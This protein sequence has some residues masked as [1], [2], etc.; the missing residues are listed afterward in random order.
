MKKESFSEHAQKALPLPLKCCRQDCQVTLS[1]GIKKLLDIYSLAHQSQEINLPPLSISLSLSVQNFSR[2]LHVRGIEKKWA[3]IGGGEV[4]GVNI[5]AI[6]LIPTKP[7]L[8]IPNV[9]KK[10][11]SINSQWKLCSFRMMSSGG[12]AQGE[13][14]PWSCPETAPP[15]QRS[16]TKKEKEQRQ[17][18]G[19]TLGQ[20]SMCQYCVHIQSDP[21][22]ACCRRDGFSLDIQAHRSK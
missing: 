2:K 13:R 14:A 19:S 21:Q 16:L 6:F 17:T 8:A 5:P 3:E 10:K 18:I 7:P 12:D 15:H 11:K 9:K 20:Q 22:Q 1:S 4:A